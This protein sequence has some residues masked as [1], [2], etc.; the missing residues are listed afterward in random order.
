MTESRDRCQVL[1]FADLLYVCMCY[2]MIQ[3]VMLHKNVNNTFCYNTI[4]IHIK[5]VLSYA[6]YTTIL[7]YTFLLT[8]LHVVLQVINLERN[9]SSC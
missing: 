9:W 7:V 6:V 1:L 4:C 2:E 3:V 5:V 8:S